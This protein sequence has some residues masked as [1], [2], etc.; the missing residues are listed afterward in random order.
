MVA[1]D[2]GM[3]RGEIAQL[4]WGQIDMKAHGIKLVSAD[5]KSDE[6]RLIPLTDRLVQILSASPRHISGYVFV[7]RNG[8]P[9]HPGKISTAFKKACGRTGL[10]GVT[11]HDLRHSFCTNMR[12]AG[13]DTLTIMAISDHRNL[14][15][16]RHF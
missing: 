14:Y 6:N 11:S 8:R 15:G 2:S 3:R 10:Q 16:H 4:R 13:V 9:Y 7:T 1:Y 5:T 12:R